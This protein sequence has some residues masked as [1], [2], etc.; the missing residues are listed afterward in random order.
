M[1]SG[2]VGRQAANKSTIWYNVKAFKDAGIKPPTTWRVRQG[3]R[4]AQGVGHPA[5]S[6]GGADGWTLTDLFENIYLRQA[7]PAKYDKLSKHQIKWTDPTVKTALTTMG[8]V[9]GD[10]ATSPAAPRARCR[11]TSR[12]RSSNVFT[13]TPKAAMVIEGDFVPGVVATTNPVKPV[14]DYNVF[15]FPSIDGRAR[16]SSAAA[17]GRSMFKDSP[18]IRALVN[19]PRESEARDDL[20]EARRLLLAEQERAGE[21]VPRRDHP[22]RRRRRSRKAKTFRFDISDLQP[23]AFGGTVGQG[24]F[25]I[26]QDFLKNPNNVDG[27][28]AQLEAAAAKAYKK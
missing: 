21:R 9:L 24:E 15:P 5:Y 16:P 19:V 28:A 6:I 25:K 7:G 2:E 10:S 26:F 12:R 17:T 1:S 18:A 3:R 22:Q 11:P 14:T 27:I 20:G 8:Q 13:N 4:H 23:A